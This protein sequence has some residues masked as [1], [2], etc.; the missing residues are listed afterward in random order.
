MVGIGAADVTVTNSYDTGVLTVVK[1]VDGDGA[2]LYGAE[3]F[4]FTVLCTYRGP[5]TEWV[6]DAYI[7]RRF[8]GAGAN[9][10]PDAS[11]GLRLPGHRIESI[12]PFHVALLKGSLWQGNAGRGIGDRLRRAEPRDD[13]LGRDA[14]R[15]EVGDVLTE[16]RED[17]LALGAGQ[18]PEPPADL[19]EVAVKERAVGRVGHGVVSSTI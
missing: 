15:L 9:G 13:L 5:G 11:S 12:D 2:A 17:V 6:D 10:Q 19:G 18:V 7:D 1:E 3:P 14:R 16:A 8:L 4:T